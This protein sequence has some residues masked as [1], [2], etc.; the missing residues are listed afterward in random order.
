MAVINCHQEFIFIPVD[1]AG[2]YYLREVITVKS[3]ETS[4]LWTNLHENVYIELNT[5]NWT[6]FHNRK[7]IKCCLQVLFGISTHFYCVFCTE[8]ENSWQ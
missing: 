7:F 1:C 6:N 4:T 2:R 8:K 5:T 3:A